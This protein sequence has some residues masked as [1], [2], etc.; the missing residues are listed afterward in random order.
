MSCLGF[1]ETDKNGVYQRSEYLSV[2]P[3]VSQMG[4]TLPA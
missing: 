2:V 3:P 1:A 4:P